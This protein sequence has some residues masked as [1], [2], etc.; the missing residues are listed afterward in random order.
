MDARFLS[1]VGLWFGTRIGRTQLTPT[2]V[3]DK[4][5]FPKM[6]ANIGQKLVSQPWA[7]IP[8][9]QMW[10]TI[11][12]QNLWNEGQLQ[13]QKESRPLTKRG[14]VKRR[15]FPTWTFCPFCL[16]WFS[17]LFRDFGDFSDIFP[18]GP[19]LVVGQNKHLQGTFPNGSATQGPFLKELENPW[20][21]I[22]QC[23][24]S[25]KKKM[26][27]WKDNKMR[28]FL[29]LQNGLKSDQKV[30]LWP[31]KW[32][33]SDFWYP[34]SHFWSVLSLLTKDHQVSV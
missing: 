22:P 15:G 12:H 34:K 7:A 23:S 13:A 10:L 2:P 26:F 20:F 16:F 9:T 6:L 28:L 33:K 8:V 21:G 29:F 17:R 4:N 24:F 25:Q 11:G 14:G 31:R 27:I 5:R 19:F 32:L 1:S 3:P 30:T 18:I